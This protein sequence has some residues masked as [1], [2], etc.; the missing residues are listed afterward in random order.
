M[1]TVE[2]RRL[3]DDQNAVRIRFEL[4]QNRVL[5]FVV[6]LECHYGDKWHP[7]VRYDTAHSSAHRDMLH[8]FKKT[9]KTQMATQDYNQALTFAIKDLTDSWERYRQRYERW[10]K[11]K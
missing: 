11:Q 6:Q 1:R 3:L 2:Y 4:E 5:R 8:P 10:L 7:V 9:V